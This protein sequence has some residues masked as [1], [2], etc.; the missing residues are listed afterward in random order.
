MAEMNEE[1]MRKRLAELRLQLSK[2]RSQ[3]GIGGAPQNSGRTKETRKTIARILT[4]FNRKVEPKAK[5]VKKKG[6]SKTG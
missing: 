1:D 3:I 4:R 5:V 6:G 2:D